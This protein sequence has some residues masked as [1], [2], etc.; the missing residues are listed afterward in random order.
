VATRTPSPKKVAQQRARVLTADAHAATADR[1]TRLATE[2]G[3]YL[4]A[5]RSLPKATRDR[6]ERLLRHAPNPAACADA[7]KPF[8]SARAALETLRDRL[9]RAASAGG[10]P[11]RRRRPRCFDPGRTRA[12]RSRLRPLEVRTR[13]AGSIAWTSKC[14]TVGA[15]GGCDRRRMPRCT[16]AA[17]LADRRDS[18]PSGHPSGRCTR[19]RRRESPPS[20]RRS[21]E[22]E[23]RSVLDPRGP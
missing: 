5:L 22:A 7:V 23:V 12:A 8:R 21:V 3:E 14:A 18:P 20:A 13:S 2:Q 19:P 15:L 4:R 1:R 11:E 16:A 10:G 6:V 17:D 9:S